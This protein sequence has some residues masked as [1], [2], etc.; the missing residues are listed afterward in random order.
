[1]ATEFISNSWLMPQNSN[2]DK[3][4]NYSLDFDGTADYIDCG[5]NSSLVSV[6]NFSLSGWFYFDSVA[7]NKT[8]YSYGGN[9]GTNQYSMTIQT[10][11]SG[12]L[13]FVIANA[14]T[15]AGSNYIQTNLA[16][17][18]TTSTWYHIVCTYDGSQA[19]NTDKAK[20]YINGTEAAYAAGAGTI[21]ATTSAS[22]GTFNIGR[23][24]GIGRYF[25]GKITEVSIFNY[26]LTSANITSI[27]GTGSAI[28]NPM[29]LS[30]KPIAYYPLGNSAFNNEFL[31]TNKATELFE[32]YSIDIDGVNDYI[33]V[34]ANP[35][36]NF[37]TSVW[38]NRD[39]NGNYDG[40]LGQG[41][42][43]AQGGILRY[44]A[45]QADDIYV[46]LDD[47]YTVATSLPLN[48]WVHFCLTYDS[49]ADEL[50]SYIDGSLD[51][52]ISSPDFSGASTNAHSFKRIGL[53]NASTATSFPG[54]M[55]N[56]SLFNTALS[57]TQIT[58]LYN[59]GKPF[60]LNTFAVTPVAWWRLGGVN[61]SFDGTNWTFL[62]EIGT[63]NATSTNMAQSAL[64]D[65][66]GATGNGVSSGMSSGTNRSDAPYSSSNSVSYNMAV[67]AKSTLVPT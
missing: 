3:L 67:T 50:K 43:T 35:L 28:G 45:L 16:S 65:G 25:N 34:D 39:G 60:D 7:N 47:W 42:A 55:S 30:T 51:T 63:N 54:K 53:R 59:S 19:G 10:H 27:Y 37:T 61:S 33:S 32:N 12:N 49:T 23:W 29:S 18:L 21:P 36:T 38:F 11:A 17:V 56:V 8:L 14:T 2:Q 40:I 46:F 31:A 22:T 52:T 9:T 26:A 5:V 57:A 1:M 15:D 24:E 20:I 48:T 66:V 62:D 13:I 58:T 64:V 4:A 44:V 6:T 41:T